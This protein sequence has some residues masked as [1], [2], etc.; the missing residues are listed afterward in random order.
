MDLADNII[1]DSTIQDSLDALERKLYNDGHKARMKLNTWLVESG[2]ALEAASMVI[3]HKK[4]K[5]ID[6]EDII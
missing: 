6:I 3:N 2:V 4:R 1:S 5:R